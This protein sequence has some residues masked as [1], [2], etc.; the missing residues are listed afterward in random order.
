MCVY[1]VYAVTGLPIH[2]TSDRVYVPRLYL[3]TS[4]KR[5]Y[6]LKTVLV[7][8]IAEENIRKNFIVCTINVKLEQTQ[9][10]SCI[11]GHIFR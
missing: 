9:M 11:L 5:V 2:F 4:D 10:V 8:F 3:C 6:S 7:H 1:V